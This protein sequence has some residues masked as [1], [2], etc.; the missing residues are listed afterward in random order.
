M[1]VE[2]GA[3]AAR[4][5]SAGERAE[6]GGKFEELLREKAK[7]R[8][9][10]AVEAA[11]PSPPALPGFDAPATEEAPAPAV[12]VMP[13]ALTELVETMVSK[14]DSMRPNEVRIEFEPGTLDGLKV[15]IERRGDA[16]DVRFEATPAVASLL[17]SHAGGLREALER[18]GFE[19]VIMV[20][21]D[22]RGNREQ[23]GRERQQQ[24]EEQERES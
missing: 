22:G 16:L 15:T 5:G 1:K 24:S 3:G 13:A 2:R 8:E 12:A 11:A 21:R 18:R 14:I 19:P 4:V 6:K 10:E 7:R 23:R 20:T 9:A 17:E